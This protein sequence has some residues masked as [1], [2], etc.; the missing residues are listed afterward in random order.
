MSSSGSPQDDRETL[1]RLCAS[2]KFRGVGR[3]PRRPSRWNPFT[4]DKPGLEAYN[5]KFQDVTAFEFCAEKL[6][7]GHPLERITLEQPEGC[8]GYVMRFPQLGGRE[9]YVKLELS[10]ARDF[11]FGRSFH[12]SDKVPGQS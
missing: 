9:L 11:V 1:A 4:V 5:I 8:Y 10:A 6:Q 3:P 12:Y 2:E 7:S